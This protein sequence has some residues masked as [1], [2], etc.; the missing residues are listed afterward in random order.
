M[1][2]KVL[3]T[4]ASGNVGREVVRELMAMDAPVVAAVMDADDE[5]RVATQQDRV[6]EVRPFRF[7]EP[8]TYGAALADVDRLFLMRPPQI[9]NVRRYLFP[10]IDAAQ[11]AGVRHCVF[12]SLLGVERNRLVPHYRVES[13]LAA[14]EM[15]YTFLRPS[16]YMQN[17]NTMHRA[18]IRDDGVIAVPVGK[19]RTSFIDVRD[20]GAV[21][22]KALAEDGD[23]GQVYELTGGEAL[24]YHEVADIFTDV[25]GRSI[26]YTNPS[27]LA[28]FRR[29]R[30][31]GAPLKFALVMV[32]LYTATRLGTADRVT[33]TVAR[34][35]GRPPITMR[36]YVED[37]AEAWHRGREGMR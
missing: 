18:E 10:M 35:L 33:E 24:D 7:G 5:A 17:L 26:T 27:I 25:L 31:K 12:L 6:P 37:Y 29:Q 32:G 19:A 14:G 23:P 15:P 36:Q 30:A 8:E 9:A 28:F 2:A 21:A 34:L 4:G 1:T 22:A 13:Y 20:I 3:V 16:F 11:A